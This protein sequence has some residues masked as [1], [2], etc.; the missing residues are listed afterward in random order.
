LAVAKPEKKMNLYIMQ[1]NSDI[2]TLPGLSDVSLTVDAVEKTLTGHGA[3]IYARI[4]Q[5][6]EAAKAGLF[7]KPMKLLIFGNPKGGIP[8][9]NANPL[10]GLDLP[11]KILVWEDEN[12]KTWLSYN[13]FSYLQKRFDLPPGLIQNLSAVENLIQQA[14]KV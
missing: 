13:S 9:M 1:T 10:C 2:I 8:L 6:A 5:E 7:L 12:M 4:D 11:L 14:L 3:F